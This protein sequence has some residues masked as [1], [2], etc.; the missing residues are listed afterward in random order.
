MRVLFTYAGVNY[1]LVMSPEQAASGEPATGSATVTCTSGT[2]PCTS[3]TDV[4]TSGIANANVANL[5][6]GGSSPIGQYY[7]TF[8]I[9]L[10][11]P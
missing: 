5:Y 4:P 10:S 7:L 6:N 8:N 11:H 1:T 9:T 2:S 3:W